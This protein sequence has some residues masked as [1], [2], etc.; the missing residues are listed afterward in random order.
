MQSK[1]ANISE[2]KIGPRPQAETG[3]GGGRGGGQVSSGLALENMARKLRLMA[4]S[5]NH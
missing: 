1:P 2:H 4:E 5:L 3:D